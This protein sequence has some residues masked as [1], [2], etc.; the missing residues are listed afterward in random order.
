MIANDRCA[1]TRDLTAA[2]LE[3]AHNQPLRQ[4][5]AQAGQ[6]RFQDNFSWTRMMDAYRR[7]YGELLA[8]TA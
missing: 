7:H 4:Q 3:A 8:G 6:R 1:V 5:L 2:I